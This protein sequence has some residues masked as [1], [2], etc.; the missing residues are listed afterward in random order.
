MTRRDSGPQRVFANTA[1]WQGGLCAPQ[2]TLSS[3]PRHRICHRPGALQPPDLVTGAATG[4]PPCPVADDTAAGDPRQGRPVGVEHH[5]VRWEVHAV[6]GTWNTLSVALPSGSV[7]VLDAVR[8][9]MDGA[10]VTLHCSPSRGFVPTP[11]G[12][13]LGLGPGGRCRRPP[14]AAGRMQSTGLRGPSRAA[15]ASRGPSL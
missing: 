5:P 2:L 1:A 15:R 9:S 3:P 11:N 7:I 6:T 8:S 14:P 4:R 12:T 13:R 10:T